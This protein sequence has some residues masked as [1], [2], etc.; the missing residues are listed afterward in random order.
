MKMPAE[1]AKTIALL[2]S[3]AMEKT[4][5]ADDLERNFSREDPLQMKLEQQAVGS[6]LTVDGLIDAVRT[7]GG[8]VIHL[9]ARLRVPEER[10]KELVAASHGKLFIPDWR[11]WV[12]LKGK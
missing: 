12:K 8:R 9:A 11:G 1:V 5:L 7:K 6:A 3:E 2:R 4:R 10:I